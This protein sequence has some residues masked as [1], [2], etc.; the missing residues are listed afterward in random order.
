MVNVES[1]SNVTVVNDVAFWNALL[2]I[3]VTVLGISIEANPDSLNAKFPIV[4]NVDPA[5]NVTEDND[6][7]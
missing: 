5:S 7:V 1:A 6:D 4:V 2:P 3:L